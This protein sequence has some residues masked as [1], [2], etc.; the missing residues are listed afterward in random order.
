MGFWG[1]MN[2]DKILQWFADGETGVSSKCMA[3]VSC[4]IT[5]NHKSTPADPSDLNRC[6]KLVDA[7]PEVMGRAMAISEISEEWHNLM[8]H[9]DEL[10]ELFKSEVGED[11]SNGYHAPKTYERMKELNL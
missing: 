11:W 4:G 8:Y 3:L 2:K 7:V 6:I 10:V 5:P 9:W 1:E